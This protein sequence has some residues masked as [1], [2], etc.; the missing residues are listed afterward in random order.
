MI[1]VLPYVIRAMQAPLE[2]IPGNATSKQYSNVQI[3]RELCARGKPGGPY[4]LMTT[5]CVRISIFCACRVDHIAV[6]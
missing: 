5:S 2:H 4:S 6:Q 3:T 1:E